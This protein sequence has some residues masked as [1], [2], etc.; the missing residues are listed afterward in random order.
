MSNPQDLSQSKKL[1]DEVNQFLIDKKVKLVP[2]ISFPNYNKLPVELEL[3]LAV[4][5]KHEPS[6][7]IAIASEEE[8]P[9]VS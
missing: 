1:S 7:D 4:M 6:F 8:G 9:K 2:S 5:Q 3:A